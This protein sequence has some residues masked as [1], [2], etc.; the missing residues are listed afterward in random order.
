[1]NNIDTELGNVNT[2]KKISLLIIK[3][4]MVNKTVAI[5]MMQHIKGMTH[6]DHVLF[7][8][9]SNEKIF[10]SALIFKTPKY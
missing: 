4:N 10:G 7:S 3:A 9:L 1:M 2:Q 5:R 6:H 8:Y